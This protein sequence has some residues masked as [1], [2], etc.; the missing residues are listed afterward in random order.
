MVVNYKY[1]D[2]F[3]KDTVDKQLSIVSDDGKINIT[4]T[5]LHQ[6]KFELT[7]SLCSEQELTFGSCEAA[8]IKF[9]VSNTFLPMKGRWMTV[10]MSLGGHTDVP[11]QFGRYKVDSDTPT[12]DRTCRDVVAYD[13]LYDILNADVAAWYNTVFPSHKEQQKDKDGKTTTVTVYDPVTMKQFRDSFFKYFG[14]EQADIDLIND[15][16]SIE[17]TVAVTPSSETSSD[18]EE[19][20]TIGESVSGKEVLSCICEINGCM[21]HM[22]RDGKFHYIYLEQEIQGLYPRNDLYPADDLFPRDPKSTQIGKGF[23]VTAT[24]EDYLVKTI[25]KL[26]I[27]EQKNDIGVI[28]GTG[29]NAY[30]IEDNF[31]VYGKGTKELKSIANN[32]LSKIRGIVY[33]P[34]TAD[35]KGNPCLEVGD[36]VRLPTRYELIE[37]YILK[38]T[39]KGIQALRD[40]LE[41]DGEEYRTNGANGIQ[42]SILKLK[43]KSNVLERTIEK[44]QSTITDVEKGLQS[45]ITQTATEIRTEVKNTTDG[46]SS[47]ITQNASSITA[48][49]KRAQGQEIEL[50]AAI[51]I[52]E[53]KITAEV[54][55][56][57]EAEGD[58]SGNIEVTATKIRSEVS[59]SLTVWDTEDYDVTHCGFGNP[60]NTYPAS[61]YYSGHSFLDQ[62]TGKFYGC[63]PDGGIS[64]GKYKWTLI[65]KFKQL[66]S[67]ASSTITQS[68]KQIS[69]KVSKDSV[70]SEI[71]QSAEGIKIKAKLL[72]LKGSMEMTGGYMHIQAEESV[73]NLI[74]FKRSG[75]LV[76]MGTD[77]FRT[78]EGTLESPVHKCTVQYNQVSLHKGANDNDHMMIHLD[79]DTGVGGFRGGVING[80]DKRIKNTILDLSKKQSSEFIYSLRAKSYRYNFE[81][82][83]FH[84]G[85]IAQDVLKKAEKGWNI[86]PKTFSDS[87]GKKYYGLKYTE[88]I[89]DLV[90]TVQLQHEEIEN[91][92]EK[93]ESL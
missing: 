4:N 70:I 23:Y 90:A 75:T 74:E 24:Y 93:V 46:L 76:Q 91:L 35:C 63:E 45:Q 12:A 49:V 44:T 25:N 55:R 60:Q 27:R 57:S 19:S 67:S 40:D 43:G 7:E 31:L 58:L 8:M 62:K 65:K 32:V 77:G 50:A 41:T 82:D 80:S 29:D 3:K 15:N 87:N 11:F 10:R 16:M 56:A 42:K 85:F 92:K 14:I 2:L 64:S 89:A 84:H 73:E 47:R 81:K 38:R 78:V 17:K 72:E 71:N 30:V 34:F 22:G 26:Q 13:A 86:C 9:T 88:L 28:V 39:L 54:T 59:A 20:S 61:S 21:G 79:G 33:R 51:K 68:S 83:G 37:S 48:E 69:L 5:E 18:T 1:G 53:D 52:N 36:A 6:E 66:S